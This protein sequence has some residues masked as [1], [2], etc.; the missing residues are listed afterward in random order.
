[1]M[2]YY[3]RRILDEFL[4]FLDQNAAA[5]EEDPL[6]FQRL[7]DWL[8]VEAL[9][10]KVLREEINLL[11]TLQTE[12]D[13]D[14]LQAHVDQTAEPGEIPAYRRPALETLLVKWRQN[15]NRVGTER[16]SP[17]SIVEGPEG[18]VTDQ[19]TELRGLAFFGQF[20]L[21]PSPMDASILRSRTI[22]RRREPTEIFYEGPNLSIRTVISELRKAFGEYFPTKPG[23]ARVYKILQE[24]RT[25][26]SGSTSRSVISEDMANEICQRLRW[27]VVFR[28]R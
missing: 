6:D 25:K 12:I 3:E 28:A 1:M 18:R 4:E 26:L 8:A 5:I 2:P 19:F 17:R 23:Q 11:F 9:E 7:M 27:D 22:L 13:V 20:F 21:R 15:L 24:L 14:C 10:S 16:T